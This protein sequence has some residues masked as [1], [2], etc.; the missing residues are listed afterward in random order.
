[1]LSGDVASCIIDLLE[2]YSRLAKE[3]G[4]IECECHIDKACSEQCCEFLLG[5]YLPAIRIEHRL[6]CRL[7]HQN[8][9][10]DILLASCEALVSDPVVESDLLGRKYILLLACYRCSRSDLRHIVRDRLK[11]DEACLGLL[12]HC[13]VEPLEGVSLVVFARHLLEDI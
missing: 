6:S 3:A 7:V 8:S 12:I 2:N 9:L 1:M 11:V 10:C 13:E 4:R 5:C